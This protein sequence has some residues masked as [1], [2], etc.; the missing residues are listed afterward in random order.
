MKKM[1]TIMA[2]LVFAISMFAKDIKTVVFTTLPQMHCENCENKIKG[3]LRFEKGIKDIQTSVPDQKVTI[4]YDADKT[5]PGKI[6]KGFAKIGYEATVV[7]EEAKKAG[8]SGCD[9]KK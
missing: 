4:Q 7:T 2:M 9:K 1:M 3:N 8:R 5:N 6:A